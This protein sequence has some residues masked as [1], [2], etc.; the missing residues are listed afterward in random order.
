MSNPK[1]RPTTPFKGTLPTKAV[2]YG[3]EGTNVR[4]LQNFL[5][6]SIGTNISHTGKCG[7]VTLA[8]IKKFQKWYGLDVDGVFGAKSL[9]KARSIVKKYEPKPDPAPQP[10]PAPAPVKTKQDK[11]L[12]WAKKIAKDDSWTYVHY[13]DKKRT[14]ECPIC[15]HHSKGHEH[16]WN[17][18]GYAWASWR[19]GAGLKSKC[20]CDAM[21][22]ALY[23]KVLNA[24]TKAKATRIVQDRIGLND[25]EVI[26]SKKGLPMSMAQPGDIG[27]CFNGKR[28]V[29]TILIAEDGKIADCTSGRKDHIKYG[30]KPYSR[31]QMKI[32]I[33]YKGK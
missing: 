29:H 9:K 21:T 26:R 14:H 31:W 2:K 20:S 5:N 7:K 28:Y 23:E 18:I 32:L 13:T 11:M 10:A 33:R 8:A 19:H 3:S 6:W 15:H 22:D 25:I 17:C 12:V 1:Y 4:R 16:G 27:V 30:V 24:S